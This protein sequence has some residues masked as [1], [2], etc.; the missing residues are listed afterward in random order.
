M[1]GKKKSKANN[2]YK[3][4]CND[5]GLIQEFQSLCLNKTTHVCTFRFIFF[6]D[7]ENFNLNPN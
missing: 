7:K 6:A 1:A 4:I 2:F 3:E 5:F